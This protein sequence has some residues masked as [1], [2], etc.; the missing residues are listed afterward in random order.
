MS[1]YLNCVFGIKIIPELRN[2]EKIVT[3][4]FGKRQWRIDKWGGSGM[5]RGIDLSAVVGTEVKTPYDGICQVI[6]ENKE[7][8]KIKIN[9]G[10]G[11]FTEYHHLSQFN[12]IDGQSITSGSVIALSGNTSGTGKRSTGAHLHFGISIN[13][14]YVDPAPYLFGYC[15][16]D[17]DNKKFVRDNTQTF[18]QISTA[19]NEE[20]LKLINVEQLSNAKIIIDVCKTSGGTK[21]DAILGIMASLQE[22]NLL[23][24]GQLF[25]QGGAGIFQ[26]VSE[27]GWGPIA[28]I[29]MPKFAANSFYNGIGTNR[30]L[31]SF[32]AREYYAQKWRIIK[33]VTT[34]S[35]WGIEYNKWEDA[36]T[37]IV[38]YL[39]EPVLNSSLSVDEAEMSEDNIIEDVEVSDYVAA[40]I[41]QA[42]KVIIDPEVKFREVN[43]MTFSSL[44]GSL[45]TF[46]QK[47]CQKPFV[48]FWGD[49][50]GDQYYFIIRKQPFTRKSF[51]S[52]TTLTITDRDVYSDSFVWENQEIY[53]W[54]KLIP[55][56][57]YIGGEEQMQALKAVFFEEY[58]EI[59]G[60]RPLQITTNYITFV[61]NTGLIAL[62]IAKQ[63][64]RFIIDC[65]SYLPFVRKGTITIRGDRRIK[66]GM[67][68]YYEPTD[69][70]YYI[71]SVSNTF[72][73]VEGVMERV[74][75][76]TVSHG[77]KKF[78]ADI[79][80]KDNYTPS[81][82]NLIRY[83]EYDNPVESFIKP[84][85]A[86]LLDRHI[87]YFNH[88]KYMFDYNDTDINNDLSILSG[89]LFLGTPILD[90][91]TDELKITDEIVHANMENCYKIAEYLKKYP[92]QKFDLVGNT[93]EHNTDQYNVTLGENRA[94]T[95]REIIIQRY[96]ENE[97]NVLNALVNSRSDL[98]NRLKI[99][100]D[101][102]SN[103]SSNNKN[104]LG[105]LKNR[106]VDI[107][108]ENE[109]D[110]LK[111]K[112]V[113]PESSNDVNWGVNKEVFTFFLRRNQFSNN[114][115]LTTK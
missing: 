108:Y 37:K 95:I 94:K 65:H 104:P 68:I 8:N 56:G 90:S 39:W 29:Y 40:G 17:G 53:S 9:H 52:L 78:Y 43:D 77:M 38:D 74:T 79:E 71:E 96:Y 85:D 113:K 81:Y 7:G 35:K 115:R 100:S 42:I 72:S 88:D 82:F 28:S 45:Y 50:Y 112:D 110:N 84:A 31:L 55:A 83:G 92:N 70:Y 30:G 34:Y 44:Q 20:L 26:Q 97:K 15:L 21:N 46:F 24:S 93:D 3:D 2:N 5:H 11:F 102:E 87:A 69:E 111:E 19:G 18:T 105:R 89:D 54:Y 22:G 41:W 57:N 63:D 10:D 75:V 99:R 109:L 25:T 32:N 91:D 27:K 6:P 16:K 114:Y 48:E 98:E 36:A 67:K 64:L 13:G 66:R 1:K 60:S 59:W 12:V 62:E 49:T 106:R 58:A 4:I 61:K 14:Q 76:L 101:G 73:I 33:E 23:N 80:I 86:P 47:L 103:P 107:Y 51:L